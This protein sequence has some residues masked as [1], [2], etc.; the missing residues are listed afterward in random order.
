MP[1]AQPKRE[2]L[3]A[4]ATPAFAASPRSRQ[5]RAFLA[6]PP[7]RRTLRAALRLG[8]VLVASDEPRLGDQIYYNVAANQLARATA[9]RTPRRL[10]DASTRRS[11]RSRS[12]RRPGSR[13][14]SIPEARHL[15]VQ[16]LT[17]AVLGAGVVVLIRLVGRSV[18]GDRVGL[19]K[20][21]PGAVYPNLWINDGLVMAETLI[22]LRSH[23]PSCS[24]CFDAS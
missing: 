22:T 17:M 23:W 12:R 20:R 4:R 15:L 3:R 10:A 2:V 1:V 5:H 7:A 13:S 14:R 6:H 11:R 18:G 24:R 16:R 19:L 8:Y 9:S 21:W